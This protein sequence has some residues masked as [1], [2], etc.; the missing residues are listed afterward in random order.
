MDAQLF[1]NC[2]EWTPDCGGFTSYVAKDEDEEL[3]A[4]QPETNSLHLVY[5]DV[6]TLKFV[7]RV[8]DEINRL[9]DKSF[10]D[11]SVVYYE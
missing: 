8:T 2:K 7:K 11:I 10:H 3:L 4:A 1:F 9:P 5:R 6:D